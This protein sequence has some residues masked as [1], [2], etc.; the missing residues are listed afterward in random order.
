MKL[1][2]IFIVLVLTCLTFGC[3]RYKQL[4]YLDRVNAGDTYSD[5][6]FA[7]KVQKGDM[8]DISI[9]SPDPSRVE[10]FLHEGATTGGGQAG[11]AMLYLK[12][13]LVDDSGFVRIPLAG[14][15][16][17]EGLTL[18]EIDIAISSKLS[19]YLK[20]TTVST[21][22][23]SF[24]ITVLGEVKTPGT[25]FV[26][27]PMLNIYQAIGQAGDI[28]DIGDRSR[29][30]VMRRKGGKTVVEE[31]N[32]DGNALITSEYMY[33][34][35]NDVVYVLPLKVKVIRANTTN[36]SFALSL[37]TLAVTIFSLITLSNR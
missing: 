8:L 4:T 19:E 32:L 7:Y 5:S 27:A 15:V 23:L 3:V 34:Q 31:V 26:Y 16:K 24:R 35:P 12:S 1:F 14:N 22:L 20:F 11:P 2:R 37:I 29:V 9:K 6:I 18:A 25:Q 21:K 10:I 13:Y 36:V 30:K 17:V 28:T 33:L